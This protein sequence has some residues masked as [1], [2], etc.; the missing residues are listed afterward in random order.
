MGSAV[1]A[2]LRGEE[3]AVAGR[4]RNTVLNLQLVSSLDVL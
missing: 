1:A 2:N 3:S 4:L